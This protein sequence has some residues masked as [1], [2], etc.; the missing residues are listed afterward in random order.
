MNI[1]KIL[2]CL[3]TAVVLSSCRSGNRTPAANPEPAPQ[4]RPN[5]TADLI[6]VIPAGEPAKG[7]AVTVAMNSFDIGKCAMSI[8]RAEEPGTF[9][10]T[11][12]AEWSKG[13]ALEARLDEPGNAQFKVYEKAGQSV[14]VHLLVDRIHVVIKAPN[15]IEAGRLVSEQIRANIH[16][17][18]MVRYVITGP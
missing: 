1:I 3:S 10:C 13:Q 5:Y 9:Q 17:L 16:K 6:E 4:A 14:T 18:R 8:R 7:K 12:M 2:L 11:L 15:E